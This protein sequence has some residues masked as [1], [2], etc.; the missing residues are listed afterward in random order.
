[1][2]SAVRPE[3]CKRSK[4]RSTSSRPGCT[5]RCETLM[6]LWPAIRMIVNAST[7]DSPSLVSIVWRR[8]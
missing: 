3:S 2:G 5:Y 6:L 4:A 8:Q 7:P 1:L